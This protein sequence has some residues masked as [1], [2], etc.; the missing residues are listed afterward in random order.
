MTHSR[1]R[2]AQCII[3]NQNIHSFGFGSGQKNC[4]RLG[5]D[6]AQRVASPP[7]PAGKV[8][9]PY[10]CAFWHFLIRG[11]LSCMPSAMIPTAQ[12]RSVCQRATR[13]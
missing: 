11:F 2:V 1:C 12:A 4:C 13:H 3:G 6:C 8:S 10:C 5:N 9:L 7:P